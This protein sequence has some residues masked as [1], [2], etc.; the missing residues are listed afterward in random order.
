M[1]RNAIYS[2]R[3]RAARG[4][5]HE[6]GGVHISGG[7][8]LLR[9]DELEQGVLDLLRKAMRHERG[10]P[11]FVNL[12]MERIAEE[13]V[14]LRCALPI[15]TERVSDFREGRRLAAHLLTRFGVAESV[16]VK[17][18]AL[19]AGGAA[20]GGKVMR[21]GVLMNAFTGQRYEHD[22]SRGV[23]VSRM[24]WVPEVQ[25][26][27]FHAVTRYGFATTRIAEAIAL[28][29]KV[30]SAPGMVAEL[31]WSDDPGYTTGYVASPE[32]GY[33]RIT[34]L[35]ERGSRLGGRVF[36]M[37]PG[38]ASPGEVMFYLERKPVWIDSFP[39]RPVEET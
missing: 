31:C 27:W 34:E 29:T 17:A 3:M 20:P 5:A 6:Q 26:K 1:S 21:G 25:R 19:I 35:K 23:R 11:D 13:E 24:D 14:I 36:F 33:V 32:A 15:R 22:W 4:A 39:E 37:D 10:T 8:R 18:I 38:K 16:A 12:K 28:A 30:A 7:E 2:L 9:A